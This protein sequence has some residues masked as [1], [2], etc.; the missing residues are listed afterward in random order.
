MSKNKDKDKELETLA[1]QIGQFADLDIVLRF[2][3]AY[4]AKEGLSDMHFEFVPPKIGEA[5]PHWDFNYSYRKFDIKG[6]NNG[7]EP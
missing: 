4:M 7:Q 3:N 2:M 1:L 6:E 5:N